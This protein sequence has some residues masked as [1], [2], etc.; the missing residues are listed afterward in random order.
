MKIT[1]IYHSVSFLSISICIR[2]F[3]IN[4]L[5]L[6]QSVGGNWERLEEVSTTSES[7]SF[8]WTLQGIHGLAFWSL[9]W[10]GIF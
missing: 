4:K 2:V 1:G 3:V 7:S 8:Q 5:L 10:G 6:F 9:P